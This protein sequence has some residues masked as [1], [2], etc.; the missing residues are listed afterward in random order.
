MKLPRTR[1]IVLRDTPGRTERLTEHLRDRGI[2]WEPFEGV[3]ARRWGLAT[4]NTYE[5]DNP[6]EGH[7]QPQK[8]VGLCLS[9]YMLWVVQ[10]ELGLSEQLILEDDAIFCQ[11][12]EARYTEAREHLPSDWD[13]L[14][15]GS[16]HCQFRAKEHVSG[17]IW[18]VWWPITTHAYI[19]NYKAL[20]TLLR[21]QQHSGAPIDI[22]LCNRSFPLLNVYTLLPRIAEQHLTP[23]KD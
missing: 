9:H 11:D 6:G 23:L 20:D 16:A 19:I 12:W 5:L 8:H 7:I 13:I 2:E 21:T 14:M 10:K 18:S 22:A 17:P 3:N 1:A 15:I 4:L